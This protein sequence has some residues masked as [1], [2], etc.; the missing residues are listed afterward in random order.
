MP[1]HAI[2]SI[3]DATTREACMAIRSEFYREMSKLQREGARME[4]VVTKLAELTAAHMAT[5]QEAQRRTEQWQQSFSRI[6]EKH[7]EDD[8]TKFAAARKECEEIKKATN[9]G[10]TKA[11][12]WVITILVSLVGTLTLS[13]AALAVKLLGW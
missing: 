13:T 8:N 12:R 9:D 2:A 7:S 10:F 1:D 6:F 11:M 5:V 3:E 4:S